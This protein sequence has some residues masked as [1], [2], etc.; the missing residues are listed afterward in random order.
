VTYFVSADIYRTM[1]GKGHLLQLID[2]RGQFDE[3]ACESF[4]HDSGAIE[5]NK[6]YNVISIMGPQSS[7]KST[8]MN[9]AFGTSFQEMDELS[10]YVCYFLCERATTT[11]VSLSLFSLLSIFRC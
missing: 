10:G 7:G 11:R 2:E 1:R 6:K 3:N 4:L 9:H 8:L 5:W